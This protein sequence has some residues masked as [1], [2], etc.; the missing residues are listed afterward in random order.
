M[1]P[2]CTFLMVLLCGCATGYQNEQLTIYADLRATYFEAKGLSDD[3]ATRM[4]LMSETPLSRNALQRVDSILALGPSIRYYSTAL[5][6]QDSLTYSYLQ[7]IRVS[8]LYYEV[9]TLAA[10]FAYYEALPWLPAGSRR[11]RAN[12]MLE[13]AETLGDATY[14]SQSP[15]LA[16][17]SYDAFLYAEQ[18][19][20]ATKD[21][22][23]VRKVYTSM[24]KV[25]TQLQALPNFVQHAFAPS[26]LNK[27]E[28]KG[29]IASLVILSLVLA[30]G[31]GASHQRR[32]AEPKKNNP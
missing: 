8:H 16:R 18:L 12:V 32:K 5:A 2:H 30:S 6:E 15:N 29:L 23:L 17:Q 21:T 28:Q 13:F 11:G 24:E 10:V 20:L 4:R 9:D 1:R 31:A 19:A 26:D 14:I 25:A 3:S 7:R 27:P 22:L